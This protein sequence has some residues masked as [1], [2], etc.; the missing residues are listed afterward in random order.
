MKKTYTKLSAIALLLF[1]FQITVTAQPIGSQIKV[2]TDS[3]ISY[4]DGISAWIPVAPGLPGQNLKFIVGVPSWVNNLQGITT[5]V[6]SSISATT[7]VSGGNIISDGGATITARG[8]CWSMSHNPTIADAHTNDGTGVG[9]FTSNLLG[10][11]SGVLYYVRAYATN[12]AGT[13]YGNEVSFTSFDILPTITTTATTA[14]TSTT[15][16][17]GGNISSNGG[18]AVITRG[19]CWSTTANPTVAL[20]TKTT[21][22]TGIGSFVSNIT[23]LTSSTT[24]F[25]RAYATNNAGTAYGNEVSFTTSSNLI[26]SSEMANTTQWTVSNAPNAT[27]STQWVRLADTSMTSSSWKQYVNYNM[28]SATPMNGVYYFDG[29]TNLVNANY[30]VS[31][32]R[33]TNAIPI[34][35]TG[36]PSVTLK[37]Y[38]LYKGFNA[39][40]TLLEISSDNINWTTIDVN[41]TIVA[42]GYANGWKEYNISPYA[43]N[44]AQVWIRFR[45]FAPASTFSG[46]QYSGGYGWM[47]DDISIKET[48]N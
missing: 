25:L 45:F 22:G 13:A 31:N 42:N 39:D 5:T 23:G 26:W 33:L 41:P 11:T 18:S 30:G 34:V 21:D 4:W 14:I 27:I 28:G 2:G 35:T 37:F 44:K 6:A 20:N 24:Y 15:V 32:S 48:S 29:I 3:H 10:L 7:A 16:T 46:V 43:G 1:V 19:I 8:I 9:S 17:S 40:S 12:S 47:I 36:H 38:Q